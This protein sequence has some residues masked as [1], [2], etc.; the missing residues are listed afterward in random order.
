MPGTVL[1]QKRVL[2]EASSARGNLPAPPSS[3][4]K[5]RLEPPPPSSPAVAFKSSQNE[6]KNR[7]GSSQPKSTFEQD[8][9]EKLSHDISERKQNNS[10]KDQAWS[11]PPI[12]ADFDPKTTNLTFQSI[13]AEEGMLYGGQTTVRLFGVTENGNSV[14]LHV[15]DFKHYLYLPAPVSFTP[16]DCGPF[17]QY[18]ETRI[19]EHKPVIESVQFTMRE[20]IYGFQ[21]NIKNPYLKITLTDPRLMYTV[22][23]LIEENNANWKGMWRTGDGTIMTY[24]NIQYVLRFMVDCGVGVPNFQLGLLPLTEIDLRHVLG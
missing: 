22:R 24:D 8:F 17:Q 5:R 2:G 14:M 18:L 1:P 20:S 15:K 4:K 13:E 19:A 16:Q 7:L 21:N 23:T 12:P 9:L 10:E 11:R 6:A 3:T